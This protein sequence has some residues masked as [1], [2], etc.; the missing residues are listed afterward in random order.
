MG[1]FAV[2]A[3]LGIEPH[4]A[5]FAADHDDYQALLLKSLADRLAEAA[6]EWLHRH[7]R[8]QAWAYAEGEDLDR[9]AL[10]A[11]GYQGIR[12][13]PGYPACP[14][15][16]AKRTLFALL[17]PSD[18]V[19]MALT[20]GMAMLPAASVSGWH[21]AHP[22]AKYFGIGHIGEDQL[23]DYAERMEWSEKQAKRHLAPLLR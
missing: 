4:L 12:P 8:T 14:D 7:V 17:K 10:I 13:A 22:Q 5:R 1:A 15:H 18:R 23:Q 2:T 11:E 21:F 6:A 19:G 20:E 3:G 9:S 16:Q